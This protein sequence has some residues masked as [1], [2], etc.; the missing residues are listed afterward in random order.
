MSNFPDRSNSNTV[1]ISTDINNLAQGIPTYEAT[2]AY[3]QN[4][5]VEDVGIIYKSLVDSNT[6][7]TPS[8]SPTQWEVFSG[9]GGGGFFISSKTLNGVTVAGENQIE[10]I[11]DDDI[12]LANITIN[13]D[14]APTGASIVVDINK[15]GTTIFTTQ[16]NR[17]EIAISGTEDTSGT[18]DITSLS[19]GDVIGIS[20]DQV[21]LTI[22]GGDNLYIRFNT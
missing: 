4:R 6:G 10:F 22:N 14:T 19:A 17:P 9:G 20:V 15:N 18:P 7:N 5:F 1:P 3:A 2:R 11:L 16:S 13:V 8:S 21:G 12:T